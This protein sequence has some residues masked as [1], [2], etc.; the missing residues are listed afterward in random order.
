MSAVLAPI[1]LFIPGNSFLHRL[2]PL[3]K[4]AWIVS[5][6]L[7]AFFMR[8]PLVLAIVTLVGIC[9][10]WLSRTW[11]SYKQ[12]MR[13]LLPVVCALIFFQFV[14][15]AYPRPWN[16][17]VPLGPLTIY[18]EGVYSGLVFALMI[19]AAAT[20]ALVGVMTTHPGDLFASLRRLVVPYTL[21]FMILNT[22]QLIPILQREFNIV[23]NA[24]RARGMKA[25]GIGALVPSM[26]PVFAGAIERVQ[27]LSMSLE[28]RA[29]G[30][31]G[32][33]TSL[34][35]ISARPIDYVLTSLA[36]L[37]L[38]GTIYYVIRFG[39][40]DWSKQIHWPP[41]FAIALFFSAIVGFLAL[42]GSFVLQFRH[43]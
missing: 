21:N 9:L 41:A 33:K 40:P 24:Q 17:V 23:L 31:S 38:A 27:Q 18:Q 16:P 15:P 8:N 37:F 26:V 22:L 4:L 13:V 29:F 5:I 11:R 7:F 20:V 19:T 43:Q 10:V 12:S 28:S 34:R 25:T 32:K 42:A 2:H 14:A 36:V 1:M 35:E 30:S 39:T 3:T 6:M